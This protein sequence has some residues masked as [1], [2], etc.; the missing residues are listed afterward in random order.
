MTYETHKDCLTGEET[1]VALGELY[2][3]LGA[4]TLKDVSEGAKLDVIITLK[5]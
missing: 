1:A 2:D 3:W 5:K 4:L